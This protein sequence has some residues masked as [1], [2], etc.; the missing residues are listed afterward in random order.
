MY[1][2]IYVLGVLCIRTCINLYIDISYHI[3]KDIYIAHARLGPRPNSTTQVHAYYIYRPAY[4]YPCR[5]TYVVRIRTNEM[6]PA[7]TGGGIA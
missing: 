2:Y 5:H 7:W 4:V 6:M 1:I 3:C